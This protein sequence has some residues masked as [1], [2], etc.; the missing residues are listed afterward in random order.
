MKQFTKTRP[1]LRNRVSLPCIVLTRVES[2]KVARGDGQG[3]ISAAEQAARA[4]QDRDGNR[5]TVFLY[6][7]SGEEIAAYEY[8]A[9]EQARIEQQEIEQHASVI[10]MRRRGARGN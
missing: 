6:N 7:F 8:S 10:R 1:S 9:V 5:R 2:N 3:I 4:M